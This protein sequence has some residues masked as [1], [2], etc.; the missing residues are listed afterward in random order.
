MRIAIDAMGGDH[1]PAEIIRGAV[2]GLEFLGRGDQL[3]LIGI[4]D[5]VAAELERAGESGESRI[6]IEHAPQV[7]KMD[8]VPVDALKQKKDSSIVRM[9]AMAADKRVDAVISAGNTGA[10]VA[11]CQLKM[12]TLGGVGRPGI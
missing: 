11:A 9:A 1:A 10:C 4:Q 2:Q 5:V 6:V 8:D 12:R 7:I 3:V